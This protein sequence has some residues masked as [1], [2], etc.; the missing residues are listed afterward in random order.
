MIARAWTVPSG[1]L[2]NFPPPLGVAGGGD[3]GVERV[4]NGEGEGPGGGL[5][6]LQGEGSPVGFERDL[7]RDA[8]WEAA[9]GLG[10]LD[11]AGN[12][13][14]VGLTNIDGL[15]ALTKFLY[16]GKVIRKRTE[17]ALRGSGGD[18][19]IADDEIADGDRPAWQ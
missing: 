12:V 10:D 6:E 4:Q 9:T 2:Q 5:S 15:D 7:R 13:F 11:A 18:G 17:A 3:G 16:V 14:G 1:Q 8:G 19:S